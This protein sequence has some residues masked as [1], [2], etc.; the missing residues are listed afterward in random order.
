MDS[1]ILQG[2]IAAVVFH[3]FDNGYAVLRLHAE[4]GQT[5]TV[6]GTIPM[7]AVGERLMVTG[8]WSSHPSYGK[9]FEAEFLERLMPE[10]K[11]DIVSYLSSR[12]IKG[13]GPVMAGRIVAHFGEDT[14]RI[15][16][17]EPHRLAEITGISAAKAKQIGEDFMHQVGLRHLMEF[18]ALH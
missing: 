14:L 3:N 11:A 18:F 16:E 7:P 12:I 1:E 9:Q 6:V 8:H 4:N 15:M 2:T 17:R 10:T 13:I 5:Y